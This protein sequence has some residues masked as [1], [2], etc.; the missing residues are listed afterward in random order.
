MFKRS[1]DESIRLVE[2]AFQ[3]ALE[4]ER[5]GDHKHAALWLNKAISLEASAF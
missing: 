5:S 2:A 4:C 1:L 3:N